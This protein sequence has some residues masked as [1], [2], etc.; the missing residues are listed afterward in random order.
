[1]YAVVIYILSVY[2]QDSEGRLSDHVTGSTLPAIFVE[3]FG[4]DVSHVTFL[5]VLL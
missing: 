2:A 1:M 5:F 3:W 4:V